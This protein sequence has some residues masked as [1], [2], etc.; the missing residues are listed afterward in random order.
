VAVAASKIAPL[1]TAAEVAELLKVPLKSV[2]RL[3]DE[4]DLPAVRVGPRR[5]RFDPEVIEEL[6]RR[7]RPGR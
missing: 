2:Y 1:L 7:G 5:L 6:I 3:V 4:G